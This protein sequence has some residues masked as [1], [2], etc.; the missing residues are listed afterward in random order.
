MS[1]NWLAFLYIQEHL[2]VKRKKEMVPLERTF[3]FIHFIVYK[4]RPGQVHHPR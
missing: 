4:R 3:S 2:S 1:G